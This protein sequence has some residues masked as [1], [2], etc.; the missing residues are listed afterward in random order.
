MT[1]IVTEKKEDEKSEKK[2]GRKLNRPCNEERLRQAVVNVDNE[3]VIGDGVDLRP[4]KLSIYQNSL[5]KKKKQI[6]TPS[7]FQPRNHTS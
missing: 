4:R 5:P 7:I 3:V 2:N 6:T 1:K